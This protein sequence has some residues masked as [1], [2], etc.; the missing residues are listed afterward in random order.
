MKNNYKFTNNE[1]EEIS[2]ILGELLT[3]SKITNIFD[4]INIL[5]EGNESTK[6]RRLNASF[7][8]S[9]RR[10]GSG[11]EILK[12]IEIALDPVSFVN[13][14]EKFEAIRN[15][16]NKILMF[17][18]VEFNN[19]GKPISTEIASTIDDVQKRVKS[20]NEKLKVRGCHNRVLFYCNSELL[21]ENYFHS[22]F[23]AAKSLCDFI[24][25]ET[26]LTE[27]GAELIDKVFNVSDPYMILNNLKNKSKK[28]QQIG[29]A[30]MLKGINSMVRNVTAH[31]SKIKWIIEEGDAIDI[32]MIISFLHKNLDCCTVVKRCN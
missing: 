16:L 11:N 32:L 22:V 13:E 27:D 9:Q 1:I 5:E 25:N 31:E 20:L 17:N 29:L 7:I 23:E 28:N 6:W 30:N 10:N 2:K 18:G 14:Y 12:F 3:G 19:A 26:G 15:E 21:N 8:A 24:R 4:Q